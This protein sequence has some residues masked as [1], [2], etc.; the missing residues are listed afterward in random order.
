MQ[1]P[2]VVLF[3]GLETANPI[4]SLVFRLRS[5]PVGFH[6]LSWVLRKTK[7]E[8]KEDTTWEKPQMRVVSLKQLRSRFPT[9]F[10]GAIGYSLMETCSPNTSMKRGPGLH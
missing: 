9:R 1:P 10:I 5:S 2:L 3:H 6:A 4:T 8:K 7:P